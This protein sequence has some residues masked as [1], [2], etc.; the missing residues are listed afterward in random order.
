MTFPLRS[1]VRLS[2]RLKQKGV[3]EWIVLTIAMFSWTSPFTA[4]STCNL[5]TTLSLTGLAIGL[6]AIFL[7]A[8]GQN[9][10]NITEKS[11]PL[12][13]DLQ[14][15]DRWRAT[16]RGSSVMHT[17]SGLCN[18]PLGCIMEFHVEGVEK[19]LW[20][21]A[22]MQKEDWARRPCQVIWELLLICGRVVLFE[23]RKSEL[24]LI[25]S[26]AVQSTGRLI[27]EQDPR[28]ADQCQTHVNPLRLP[29]WRAN[30]C[31][32]LGTYWPARHQKKVSPWW[33]RPFWWSQACAQ[34]LCLAQAASSWRDPISYFQQSLR[35]ARLR[36][37]FK[38]IKT[39]E[40]ETCPEELPDI[41]RASELPMRTPWH[42][43]RF[44][45]SMT[46][47]TLR[48]FCFRGI[49]LSSFSSMVYISIS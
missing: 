31:L 32:W 12:F 4:A 29:T 1:R 25:G 48:I 2:K 41:P 34:H 23:N 3:G 6:N 38:E 42:P 14:Y 17:Y 21:Q 37:L 36:L 24:D 9:L 45:C 16:S 35:A 11:G 33:W 10:E 13:H 47:S 22:Q 39:L 30:F 15:K 27:Q 18:L 46:A 7:P 40:R 43:L 26:K 20:R 28:V 44:S 49:F 19:F 5:S 8:F